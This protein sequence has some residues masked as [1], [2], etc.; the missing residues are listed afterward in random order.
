MSKVTMGTDLRV[1]TKSGFKNYNELSPGDYVLSC[2]L[3]GYSVW[4]QV[5]SVGTALESHQSFVLKSRNVNGTYPVNHRVVCKGT[6]GGRVII[7]VSEFIFKY[8]RIFSVAASGISEDYPIQDDMI[9]LYAWSLTDATL[10]DNGNYYFYQRASNSHKITDCLTSLGFEFTTS[11]R[12]RDITHIAGTKLKKSPEPE[13]TI[14]MR[15]DNARNLPWAG[16][17][18]FTETMFD[19]SERQV[20]L[21]VETYMD[22]DGSQHPTGKKFTGVLYSVDPDLVDVLQILL[23]AN[24]FRSSRYLPKGRTNDHRL[25]ICKRTDYASGGA[26]GNVTQSTA[27]VPMWTLELKNDRVFVECGGT[28]HLTEFNL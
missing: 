17:S 27:T 18:S 9:R 23:T 10:R 19:W 13:V 1:L 21:F 12:T 20:D 11:V 26:S 24:G 6:H 14:R 2:D 22:A 4:D 16:H 5:L 25:N 8:H 3:S 7:P 15:V 28:I